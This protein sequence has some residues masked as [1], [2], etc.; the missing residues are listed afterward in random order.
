M[1]LLRTSL[2][3]L[4]LAGAVSAGTPPPAS[5]QPWPGE[6]VDVFGRIPVQ[7]DGRVK[8]M[9][10]VAHWTL[11]ELH[12]KSRLATLTP[13]EIREHPS[14]MPA[15]RE[16]VPR[17]LSATEWLMDVLFRPSQAREYPVFLVDDSNAV[18]AIGVSAK[19]KRRNYYSYQELL[20]GRAKLSELSA[21]FAA[22]TAR[23]EK[24][25]ALEDQIAI[26]DRK[27]NTFEYLASA[28]APAQPGQL[29]NPA[30][31]D[32]DMKRLMDRLQISGLLERVP[33]M[34]MQAILGQLQQD[35]AAMSEDDKTVLTSLKIIF[36]LSR[37][38][39]AL[40]PFPPRN[41]G[42]RDWLSPGALI[43]MA[44]EHDGEERRWALERIRRL[45]KL[46]HAASQPS[47]SAG[48]LEEFRAAL[49]AEAEARG[50][51]Q[52][53]AKE[54]RLY[55]GNVLANAKVLFLA[56]FIFM[57][58]GWIHP[59]SKWGRIAA[60]AGLWSGFLALGYLA[61]G[62]ALR[63]QIRGWAPVTNLYETFLFIS[64][65]GFVFGVLFEYFN[66]KR[67]RIAVSMGLFIPALCLLLAGQFVKLNPGD[68]LPPLVAVLRSNFWLTTHVIT[69]SLGYSAGILGALVAHVWI[70]GKAFG[71]E[72]RDR[73]AY[74]GITRMV[75]GIVLFSLLFSLVGTILGGIWANY[76]WGRFW[77]WDPK[78][79]G[80]LMI[81][82]WTL[83]I[84]HVRMGGYVKDL[85]LHVLSVLLGCIIGFSWFGVNA[86]GVGLH[87][88]GFAS[89]IWKAL[90]IFWGIE[91]AVLL[92]AAWVKLRDDTGSPSPQPGS[93][94]PA[95]A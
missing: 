49:Q 28:F 29:V 52:G 10:T 94:H 80:A 91:A 54:I 47:Q 66:P 93:R 1:F 65:A 67:N 27:V 23:Q 3:A 43:T 31:I 90:Y 73:H 25:T 4:A 41:P 50:E 69:I 35:P 36:F 13:E 53:I 18:T 70:I 85:G 82:L 24:L 33:K 59:P 48:A 62:M 74:R 63:S 26:L 68:T 72:P 2:F 22:K 95:R 79:N 40:T 71:I 92:L 56:G 57:L 39:S 45:E 51:G 61:Y 17:K 55:Q 77:G 20:P 7:D 16:G 60:T 89:G 32:P 12:G 86:L 87:S 81:V 15:G 19:K 75:Y 84:L 11:I 37:S 58:L 14:S 34:P 46:A 76:S 78:E 64:A 5:Y 30:I 88:Y 6:A 21:S 38:A 9:L 8:P 42:E 44:L 83:F